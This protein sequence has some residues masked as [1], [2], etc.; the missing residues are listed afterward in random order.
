MINVKST[1][2][3]A[4]IESLDQFL[5]RIGRT[6]T[7]GWRWRR[8][9]WLKTVTIAG[10]PYITAEAVREFL[11]RAEAKEFVKVPRHLDQDS[12]PAGVT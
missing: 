12:P 10:R 8:R 9:G 5:Q 6:R 7:T 3:P 1:E 4:V 11:S 2:E